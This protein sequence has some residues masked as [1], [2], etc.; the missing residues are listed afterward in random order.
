MAAL[1]DALGGKTAGE[2]IRAIDWNALIDGV[3]AIDARLTASI[4]TL[5]ADVDAR[6]TAVNTRIGNAETR[7]TAAETRLTAAETGLTALRTTVEQLEAR[8]RRVTLTT[9]RVH[10][11]V[12]ESAEIIARLTDLR[13]APLSFAGGAALPWIDFVT[14]WGQFRPVAGFERLGGVGDRTISVRVNTAGE[15]RVLLRAENTGFFA[16]EDEL[17]VAAA[18]G[19]AMPANE[20]QTVA[21]TILG[22]STPL[23]A[24]QRGAFRA[25]TTEYDRPDARSVREFTDTYFVNTGLTGGHLVDTVGHRWRDY[26]TTVL[27]VAKADSDPRTADASLGACS[28]QVTFRDWVGPWFT[29]DYLGDVP[30][31]ADNY[32]DRLGPRVDTDYAGS[33]RRLREEVETIVGGKGIVARQRDYL[34]IRSA[35]GS[36]TVTSPPPFFSDLTESIRQAVGVQQTLD[37]TPTRVPGAAPGAALDALTESA[38]RADRNAA[39]VRTELTTLVQDRLTQVQESVRTEVR[40]EQQALRD[41]LLREDGP[42]VSVRRSLDDVSGRVAGFSQA[43]ERKADVTMLGR[44][45]PQ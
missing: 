17:E 28:L 7:L 5:A 45:I 14:V 38:V 31:L 8:F 35:L 26:R 29:L 2:L 41:D 44:L 22:S 13:G 43:L 23:E 32:R 40:A 24:S 6:F 33:A 30:L 10:Y 21:M 37:S 36:V 42:I 12:G 18:L 20:N 4:A 11:V 3:E 15:A 16:D 1:A 39:T 9:S 25:L 34:A 19:T 27:A